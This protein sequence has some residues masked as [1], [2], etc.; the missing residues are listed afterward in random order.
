MRPALAFDQEC[1]ERDVSPAVA[2]LVQVAGC[3]KA[4]G[5]E[6]VDDFP[7]MVAALLYCLASGPPMTLM[8]LFP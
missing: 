7:L 4:L 2:G 8:T 1:A 5:L 6:Q 3:G